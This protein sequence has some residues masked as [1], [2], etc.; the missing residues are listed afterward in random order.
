[1]AAIPATTRTDLRIF[2]MLIWVS[3][4]A[5]YALIL[6]RSAE[7]K[8]YRTVRLDARSVR[9]LLS[10]NRA[11]NCSCGTQIR[12][13]EMRRASDLPPRLRPGMIGG[14]AGGL[15]GGSRAGFGH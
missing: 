1:M 8:D 6:K 5:L 13:Q 14:T 4:Q 2:S 7:G 9:P 10:Q 3:S 11:L 12:P 15:D